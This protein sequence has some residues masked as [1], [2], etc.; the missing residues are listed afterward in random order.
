MKLK[1]LISHLETLAP[2]AY[3]EAYDNSGLLF[4]DPEHTLTGAIISIDCT[5]EVVEEALQK[6]CNLIISHHP[7]IFKGIKRLSTSNYV[8][9]TL[10]KAIKSD[11]AI[12]AIHTNLDHVVHGVNKALGDKLGLQN[13]RILA[14]KSCLLKKLSTYCPTEHCDSLKNALFAAGAGQIGN[15]AECSFSLA[16]QGSFTPQ[17]GAKPFVGTIG[18]R[19]VEAETKIEVMYPQ[20]LERLVLQALKQ[21]HPYE[22]VAYYLHELSNAHPEVGAGMI[23]ELTEPQDEHTFLQLVKKQLGV[24]V[25]KH[26]H[27]LGKKVKKVAICGGSG[28]FLCAQAQAAGADLF[29]TADYKYHE[30]FDADHKIVIADVGHFESEQFTQTLLFESI[31]KKFPNFALHLTE[32]VTNPIKYLI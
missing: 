3:Q 17:K 10:I 27:L 30:F 25:I 7:L 23:G 2:P 29:I 1:E 16:G 24:P 5:E 22:E 28:S 15:Y 20:H 26:T 4:G 18:T 32:Q 6:G 21:N 9:R 31:T 14:P 19:Q 13:L 12:Y 8:E 11:I